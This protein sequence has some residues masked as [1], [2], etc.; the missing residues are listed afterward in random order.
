[1]WDE[2]PSSAPIVPTPGLDPAA[3]GDFRSPSS[4]SIVPTPGLDPAACGDFRSPP[5]ASIG[6]TPGLDPAACGDFRLGRLPGS[7]EKEQRRGAQETALNRRA[8]PPYAVLISGA[9]ASGKSTLGT[10][11]APRLGAALLDID[12][13]TGPLTEVVSGLLGTADL[14]DPRIAGLT[15]AP[16]YATLLA[17]AVDNLRA[18]LPVVLVAPFTAERSADGWRA[19]TARLGPPAGGIVLVW[20]DL[21]APHLVDRLT[22]RNAARDA[23][24]VADPD[25]FVA[26]LPHH[27]PAAPHLALDAARPVADLVGQVVAHLRRRGLAIDGTP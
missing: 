2:S 19:V 20:L 17:L 27:P 4:A 7:C 12:V 18:G 10:A 25:A 14:G 9:P 1:V 22:R 5:S 11:L 23:G 8:A 13:A 3:C 16:R 6:P 21:P 15:R 24:K 26:G